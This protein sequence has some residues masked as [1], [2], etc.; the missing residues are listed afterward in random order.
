MAWCKLFNESFFVVQ[1][2]FT[3]INDDEKPKNKN[4]AHN[5]NIS[6]Q[7]PTDFYRNNFQ[8]RFWVY[9]YMKAIHRHKPKQKI[10]GTYSSWTFFDVLNEQFAIKKINVILKTEKNLD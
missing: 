7:I 3:Y 2:L 10:I 5:V 4:N 8:R 9:I 1:I 6:H